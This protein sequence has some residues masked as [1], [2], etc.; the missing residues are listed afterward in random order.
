[1]PKIKEEHREYR[2]TQPLPIGFYSGLLVLEEKYFKGL[3]SLDLIK[4]LIQLYA[5]F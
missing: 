3:I 4:E 5:V 2:E 1:M